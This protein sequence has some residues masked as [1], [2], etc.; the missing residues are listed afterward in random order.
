[1]DKHKLYIYLAKLHKDKFMK[2]DSAEY[3]YKLAIKSN[4]EKLYMYDDYNNLC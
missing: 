3:Y 4:N 2:F 1:M